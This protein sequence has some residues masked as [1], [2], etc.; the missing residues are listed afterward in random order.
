ML[1]ALVQHKSGHKNIYQ[2]IYL[3][4]K[5]ANS[6]LISHRSLWQHRLLHWWHTKTY[7]QH[8]RHWKCITTWSSNYLCNWSAAWPD[9]KNEP[10]PCKPM[11]AKDILLA[12][13][14]L[15]EIIIILGWLFN[16]RTLAISLPDHKFIAWMAA[17]QKMITLA[18]TTSKNLDITIRQMRHVGLITLWI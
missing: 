16:F 11:V 14:S 5:R 8:L 9:D 18:R 13:A 6:L 10:V 15:L 17:L 1:H 4:A 3:L 2:L 12:E 7:H